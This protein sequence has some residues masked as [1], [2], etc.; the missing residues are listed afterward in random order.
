MAGGC[1]ALASRSGRDLSMIECTWGPEPGRQ[2]LDNLFELRVVPDVEDMDL[3]R[4]TKSVFTPCVDDGKRSAVFAVGD[5]CAG[6]QAGIVPLLTSR[7]F[8]VPMDVRQID[9]A[10]LVGYKEQAGPCAK[11]DSGKAV[12][13]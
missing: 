5:K 7:R 4:V 2:A 6:G 13:R 8:Q 9:F 11:L 1:D 10:I 3:V 12:D